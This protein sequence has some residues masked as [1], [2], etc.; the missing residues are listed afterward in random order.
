MLAAAYPAGVLVSA[1]PSG[2]VAGKIGVK[3]TVV[4]GLSLIGVCT[5][6][7]GLAQEAW[8]L[9]LARFAQGV[10]SALTW[11]G[12]LG[13]LVTEAPPDRRGRMIGNAFA[14]A[15]LGALFGPVVG[16]LAS[17]VGVGWTFG[18]I[19][20][21]AFALVAWALA[22]PSSGEGS[23]RA[24]AACSA[25]SATE[26]SS[27]P[28]GS[29]SSPRSSSGRCPSWPRSGSATWASARSRSERSSCARRRSRP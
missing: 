24:R 29:C 15:V 14:A 11:T 6:L 23:R 26:A 27:P 9:D 4:I 28:P 10:A 25:R 19:G 16:G 12:A 2:V 13:W 8:Q 1:L 22:T 18:A 5:V 3:P 17:V 7:F 21:A 20:V